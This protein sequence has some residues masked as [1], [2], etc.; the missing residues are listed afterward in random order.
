[1]NSFT[2]KLWDSIFYGL[3]QITVFELLRRFIKPLQGSSRYFFVDIWVHGN[4]LLSILVL[5]LWCCPCVFW[6]SV[7]VLIYAALRVYEILI[8][9]VNVIIFGKARA[10]RTGIKPLFAPLRSVLSLLLNYLEVILWYDVFY[11][12]FNWAFSD[13]SVK[14]ATYDQ[15][16]GVS[17]SRMTY[18]GIAEV[19]PLETLGYVLLHSQAAIGLFMTVFVLGWAISLLVED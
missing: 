1:M 9:Q 18:S 4:L 7:V 12:Q 15:A 13:G 14:L 10:K 5:L 3:E 17:L 11:L 16:F 2:I 6:F 8:Y 19:M